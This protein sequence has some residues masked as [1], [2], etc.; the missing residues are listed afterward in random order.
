MDREYSMPQED[1]VIKQAEL[2]RQTLGPSG[3]SWPA[4][5]VVLT[6]TAIYFGK[7]GNALSYR[8]KASPDP[9]MPQL[10]VCCMIVARPNRHS[11]RSAP[12][13]PGTISLRGTFE[14]NQQATAHDRPK[15]STLHLSPC[16]G[17]HKL[18]DMI[19]LLEIAKITAT[20]NHKPTRMQKLTRQH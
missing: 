6:A 4:R 15:P 18:L 5:K 2:G 12:W 19:P 14:R 16:S 3:R 1:A 10:C 13:G 17:T 9:S 8:I 20:T 11:L 7:P